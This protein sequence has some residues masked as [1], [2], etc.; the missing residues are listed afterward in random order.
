MF[1]HATCVYLRGNL[2]VHLATQRKSLRKFNLRPLAPTCDYLPVHLARALQH[3]AHLK[4]AEREHANERKRR[5]RAR[6]RPVSQVGNPQYNQGRLYEY[7]SCPDCSYFA[8]FI[9][10]EVIRLFHRILLCTA[11]ERRLNSNKFVHKHAFNFLPI[12]FG[13]PESH[14]QHEGSFWGFQHHSP[15]YLLSATGTTE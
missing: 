14:H 8:L 12:G 3:L 9:E 6:I 11:V 5:Q 1:F 4:N 10:L 7:C 13:P 15:R 2:P